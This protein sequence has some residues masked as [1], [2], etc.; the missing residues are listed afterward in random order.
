MSVSFQ[1]HTVIDIVLVCMHS[2]LTIYG[3]ARV[4]TVVCV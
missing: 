4:T 3:Y 2:Q 1:L